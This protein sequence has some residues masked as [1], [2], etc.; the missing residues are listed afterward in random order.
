MNKAQRV[1]YILQRLQELY[2]ETPVPLDHQDTYTL[3]IAVLLSAQCTDERVNMVTPALFTLADNPADMARQSVEDFSGNGMG[4]DLGVMGQIV[5]GLK[6][7][8]SALNLG[9]P[10]IKLREKDETYATEYRGGLAMTLL[11]GRSVTST[12]LVHRDGPGTQAKVG[13]EFWVHSL[14]LRVGYY[15]DNVSAGF[16]YRFRNGM[17]FDYGM[18]DHELGMN[19]R[20][21]LAYRFG[22]FY[23]DSRA[24]P[25]AA[26]SANQD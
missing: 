14:A 19:H 12:E 21:G 24:N 10:T 23:A 15:I 17:Q 16:S 9:G 4:F 22:G 1:E 11:D 3:L 2:P 5:P 26:L 18:A 25:E 13:T 8:A 20:F 7:G 6:I